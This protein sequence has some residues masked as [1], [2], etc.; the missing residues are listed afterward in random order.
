MRHTA[1]SL[2]PAGSFLRC[3]RLSSCGTGSAAPQHVGS[4]WTRDRARVPCIARWILNHWAKKE[5]EVSIFSFFDEPTYIPQWLPQFIFPPAVEL[6]SLFST[7]SPTFVSGRVFTMSMLMGVRWCLFMVLTCISLII[8][9]TEHF[10][11]CFLVIN[12]S[13]L[14]KC[15]FRYSHFLRRVVCYFVMESY[16]L[17]V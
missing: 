13:S 2:H 8:S 11:L 6:G 5:R 15:L 10:F 7:P 12:V 3:T 14:E 16:E 9:D 1:P 17:F 4:S